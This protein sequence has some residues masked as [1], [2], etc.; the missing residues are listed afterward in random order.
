[1]KKQRS[2]APLLVV[3]G[4]FGNRHEVEAEDLPSEWVGHHRGEELVVAGHELVAGREEVAARRD[5]HEAGREHDD[6]LRVRQQRG[7]EER[8]RARGSDLAD[9]TRALRGVTERDEA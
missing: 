9:E 4:F 3:F 7:G 5:A 6:I 2:G 1:M 8:H